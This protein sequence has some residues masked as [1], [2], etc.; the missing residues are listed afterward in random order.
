MIFG[1]FRIKLRAYLIGGKIKMGIGFIVSDK[2]GPTV[3]ACLPGLV[4]LVVALRAA[5][6]ADAPIRAYIAPIH[7]AVAVIHGKAER[8]ART[9]DVNLGFA[10]G[11]ILGE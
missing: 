2:I 11:A 10:P 1:P 4:P 3:I 8:I 7:V 6:I 5:F 9:H